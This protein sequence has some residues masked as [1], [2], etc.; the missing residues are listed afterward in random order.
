[1]KGLI[2]LLWFSPAYPISGLLAASDARGSEAGDGGAF[3]V[4]A[5]DVGKTMNQSVM[6]NASN[7]GYSLA[8]K[9]DVRL[10]EAGEKLIPTKPFTLLPSKIFSPTTIW[11]NVVKGN[12]A[13]PDHIM[14]GEGR[15]VCTL[16][17]VM[18][19]TGVREAVSPSLQDNS[20]VSGSFAKGRS[21][22]AGL[23]FLC[24]RFGALC[25]AARLRIPL[26]WVQS[27]SQPA[28]ELSRS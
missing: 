12:F 16:A 23:N 24:R 6:S 1:M 20:A 14:L 19:R 28:D 15:A 13:T 9:N 2:P 5:A 22:H 4:V 27:G 26:P 11:H 18:C 3:G 7:I 25:M 21:A 17:N 8:Q 10:T